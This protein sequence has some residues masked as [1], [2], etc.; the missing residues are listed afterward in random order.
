MTLTSLLREAVRSARASLVPSTL[1]AVLV[2]VMCASTLLTVGR[3]AAAEV[4][5]QARLEQAGSR[6]LQVTDVKGLGFLTGSVVAVVAGLDTAERVVGRSVPVDVTNARIGSG[7]SA[8]PAWTLTGD[9]TDAVELVEGRWP[10]PGE[11]VVAADVLPTLGMDSPAGAVASVDGKM[12]ASVVGTFRAR[13]PYTDLDAGVVLAAGSGQTAHTLDVVAT[14]AS[15][16]AA[17]QRAVLLLLGRTDTTDLTLTSPTSLAEIQGA[18]LGDLSRF[19]RAAMLAVMSA[20]ALLVA[21]VAL[22][23]VLLHRRDIGRRRALGAPRWVVTGLVVARTT[24]AATVGAALGVGAAL[25]VLS[26]AQQVPDTPFVLAVAILGVLAAATAT[27]PPALVAAHQD[28]VG[29]L[30]TP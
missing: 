6:R 27:L 4:E 23:D 26:R 17:T 15:S 20:G 2:A 30:R 3:A 12:S 24:L 11:A 14:T 29:V 7:G 1:V 8:A 22:A 16:A 10:G 21:V 18:V 19:N 28:P 13:E 5:V 25:V 9:L